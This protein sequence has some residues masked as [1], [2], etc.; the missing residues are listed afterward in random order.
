MEFKLRSCRRCGCVYKPNSFNQKYCSECGKLVIKETSN[1]WK[2]RNRE[3]IKARNKLL[4]PVQTIEEV[5]RE[6]TAYNKK[7]GTHL[8]YGQYVGKKSVGALK[9]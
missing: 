6:L 8:T 5:I 2:K 9:D 7:Y 1:T 3:R 4:E